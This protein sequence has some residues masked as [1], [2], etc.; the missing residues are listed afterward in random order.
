MPPV[1]EDGEANLTHSRNGSQN[2]QQHYGNLPD[3]PQ[4]MSLIQG[5]ETLDPAM[6]TSIGHLLPPV[7]LNNE[8][9]SFDTTH[10]SEESTSSL[11]DAVQ[12]A[13][14][15]DP[16][17]EAPPYFEAG[18]G[19]ARQQV[20]TAQTPVPVPVPAAPPAVTVGTRP[21]A[22]SA[23]NNAGYRRLS[24]FRGLLHTLTNTNRP[25]I[26]NDPT[27]T[28]GHNRA[29]TALSGTSN[30]SAEMRELTGNTSRMSHRPSTSVSGSMW[31][32]ISRQKSHNTLNSMHLNSPSMISLNSISAPLSHT[33]TRTEVC[34]HFY[35]P[36]FV[37][38]FI[39][40]HCKNRLAILR[41]ARPLNR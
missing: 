35:K 17:G 24:G 21:S 27:Q 7:G 23:A 33:L 10:E 19:S 26:S 12:Q 9:R 11:M 36:Q 40:T 29:Q 13:G 8:R 34:Y 14:S 20:T 5:D 22:E 28:L 31:R 37:I 25:P 15:V 3:S 41:L 30:V 18:E 6:D 2:S 16:R 1:A 32:T 4:N 38:Q 39:L